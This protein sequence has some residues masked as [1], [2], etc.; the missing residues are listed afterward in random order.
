MPR[1][2]L[3]SNVMRHQAHRRPSLLIPFPFALSIFSKLLT[4]SNTPDCREYKCNEG[5]ERL[6]TKALQYQYNVLWETNVVLWVFIYLRIIEIWTSS[7]VLYEVISH[8]PSLPLFP[9]EL[10]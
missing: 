2:E 6:R 8:E 4:L 10:K 7:S 5:R 9:A 1:G 3:L